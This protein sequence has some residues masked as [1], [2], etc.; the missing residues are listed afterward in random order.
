MQ[1]WLYL[2]RIS[3]HEYGS[4]LRAPTAFWIHRNSIC[5]GWASV[6]SLVL[7]KLKLYL[8]C[9]YFPSTSESDM[10]TFPLIEMV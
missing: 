10:L 9:G 6:F 1:A 3:A 2:K 7:Q 5:R 8:S 4:C